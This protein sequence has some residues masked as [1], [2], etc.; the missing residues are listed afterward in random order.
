MSAGTCTSTYTA[1]TGLTLHCTGE[2][3]SGNVMRMDPTVHQARY[4]GVPWTWYSD[5]ADGATRGV[6][7]TR[8]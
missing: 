5:E 2:H 1:W 8:G 6:R 3:L 4:A 7:R